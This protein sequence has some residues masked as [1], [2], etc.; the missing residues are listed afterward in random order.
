MK[1]ALA[2]IP[3]VP[4]L[5]PRQAALKEFGGLTGRERQ[6]A[7]LIAQGKS[8]R[9]IAE[10]LVVTVRTVEAHI[11]RILDRLGF[12]SRTEIAAWAVSKGLAEISDDSVG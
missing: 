5:T 12:K 7:M 10:M 9:E 1:H 11:T 2:A 4:V 3:A 8:N 6:V